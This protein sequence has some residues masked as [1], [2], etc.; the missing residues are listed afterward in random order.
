MPL[1]HRLSSL[2]FLAAGFGAALAA[3]V[4][5][6][7]APAQDRPA[8]PPMVSSY[9]GPVAPDCRPSPAVAPL[10][11]PE[12]PGV[13]VD[14]AWPR[15]AYL[16]TDSVVLGAQHAL[17][18]KFRAACWSLRM[19]GKPAIM[20]PMANAHLRKYPKLP[21]VA[22]MAIGYNSLWEKERRNYERHAK[23]FD[24]EAE[25]ILKTLAERGVKKVVWVKI[26]EISEDN[27]PMSHGD[28]RAQLRLYA[29]Y[30]PW[31]NERLRLL[32]ERHPGLALADWP[33]A[34]AGLGYTYDGI[35]LNP[36]GAAV[37]THEIMRTVGIA[38][39]EGDRP[40]S[41]PPPVSR[42]AKPRM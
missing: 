6:T 1:P 15:E 37:M 41:A 23:R 19:D 24:D 34:G 22:I 11:A 18:Q 30:F 27:V 29:H 35:H 39:P 13:A 14:P 42:A 28:A 21:P 25:Q 26:R 9:T 36:I 10:S 32:R 5:A 3:C 4:A 7:A 8:D 16:L 2:P 12:F 31:V 38:M 20:L 33:R 40:A 17:I